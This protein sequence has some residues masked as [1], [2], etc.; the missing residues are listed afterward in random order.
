V[1]RALEA[2]GGPAAVRARFGLW[3]A[4]VLVPVHALVAVSPAPGE[5]VA[6]AHGAIYGFALGSLFTW[7]GWMLAAL[8]EY[9]IYRRIARDLGPV[10][11]LERLPRWLRRLPAH[12]PAFLA[13]T[14]FL[15][16]GNHL[17]NTLAGLARVPL[18]RFCWPT[19]LALVPIA[20]AFT[21]IA[22]GATRP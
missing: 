22:A 6:V 16:C 20:L 15:P 7:A 10:E 14:R 17:V 4:L 19:A 18:W 2:V 21:A 12:H 9:A 5:L 1:L 3:A 8:I 13:V 11:G